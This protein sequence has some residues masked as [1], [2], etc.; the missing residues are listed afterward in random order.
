MLA[1]VIEIEP[2]QILF[3]LSDSLV[4]HWSSSLM[5][6]T[7]SGYCGL[8][9]AQELQRSPT[10]SR[11]LIEVVRRPVKILIPWDTESRGAGSVS[12]GRG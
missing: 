7:V 1:H 6:S 9:P 2:N 10:A 5:A 12:V 4:G 11:C 3:R 8:R